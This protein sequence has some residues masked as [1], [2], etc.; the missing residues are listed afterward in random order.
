MFVM[1]VME[2]NLL[3]KNCHIC[4]SINLKCNQLKCTFVSKNTCQFIPCPQ[5]KFKTLY[6]SAVPH[7]FNQ[8]NKM[9]NEKKMN[10]KKII[11]KT[12]ILFLGLLGV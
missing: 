11:N 7:C 9:K 1:T 6:F 12:F 5:G 4:S 2:F 8:Q 3:R 10:E